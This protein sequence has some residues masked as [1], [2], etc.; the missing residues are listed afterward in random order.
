MQEL[1][2][3]LD[4]FNAKV[5]ELS[6]YG[7]SPA[8]LYFW[9]APLVLDKKDD[10]SSES[11]FLPRRLNNINGLTTPTQ[12]DALETG[13]GNQS[14]QDS[15]SILSRG[16]SRQLSNTEAAAQVPSP[17]LQDDSDSE[18]DRENLVNEINGDAETIIELVEKFIETLSELIG[19]E[20][21]NFKELRLD[22]EDL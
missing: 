10:D 21:M 14:T 9:P 20:T 18:E 4:I 15:S 5:A 16:G 17:S 2:K 12:N 13:D 19:V 1:N 22:P 6:N 8:S 3:Q 7:W 11:D